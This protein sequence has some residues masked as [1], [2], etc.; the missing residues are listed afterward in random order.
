MQHRTRSFLFCLYALSLSGCAAV[1]LFMLVGVGAA[2][3]AVHKVV[4]TQSGGEIKVAFPAVDGREAPPQPLPSG[5][6][7]AVWSNGEREERFIA[8]LRA[9]GTFTVHSLPEIEAS[10]GADMTDAF[11]AACQTSKADL[12]F[13]ATDEDVSK[14]KNLLSID[15]AA[16]TYTLHLLV[17]SCTENTV[18]WKDRMALI[19]EQGKI[20]PTE[21]ELQQV[22]GD[23]WAERILVAKNM[24]P[25]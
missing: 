24:Q 8:A 7:V 13:A 17:F 1:P 9:S 10:T 12:I 11:M 15:R 2:T 6:T 18:T 23:M 3:F 21:S 25:D 5:R 22:A 14:K 20:Q 16:T 4:Q 19:V